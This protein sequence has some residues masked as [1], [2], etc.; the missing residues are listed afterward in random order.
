MPILVHPL[1]YCLQHGR[2]PFPGCFSVEGTD[3][4]LNQIVP[5][6]KG[7]VE[8][9]LRRQFM[10]CETI[11]HRQHVLR[12]P[13][14]AFGDHL[15]WNAVECF[16][17][18]PGDT[19]QRIA[20][21][22]EGNR[23]PDHVLKVSSLKERGDG[24]WHRFLAALHVVVGRPDFITG[25]GK[26]IAKLVDDIIPDLILPVSCPGKED[27]AGRCLRAFDAFRMVM[28]DL[29]RQPSDPSR[30][31]QRTVQPASGRYPHGRAVPVAAVGLRILCPQPTVKATAVPSAGI[32]LAPFTHRGHQSSPDLIISLTGAVQK[33]LRHRDGHHGIIGKLCSLAEKREL[34]C[35][36]APVKLIGSANHIPKN[37]SVHCDSSSFCF[38]MA[39][40]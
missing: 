15:V 36:R 21:A 4:L 18:T 9:R 37:S 13:I 29:C 22:A 28:G 33:C 40:L 5:V 23:R 25:T 31:I 14:P 34:F 10:L 39:P 11:K 27:R 35:F 20:I 16:C 17:D 6:Q 12:Q 7:I 26:V 32:P 38:L 8:L 1:P 19:G 30:L 24:L 3:G 2:Q